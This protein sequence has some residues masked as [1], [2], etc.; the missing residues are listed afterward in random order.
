KSSAPLAHFEAQAPYSPDAVWHTEEY[1]RIYS[2]I[3]HKPIEKPLSTFSIDVDT[4]AYSNMRRFLNRAKLPPKDAIRIEE[5]LN[6]FEYAYQPPQTKA[7]TPFTVGTTLTNCPWNQN[8][9]LARIYLQ[10][11]KIDLEH[12]PPSN[13]VFLIDVSGS[14]SNPNKLPL[15]KKA[16]QLLVKNLRA[17]DRVAIIVYAGAAGVVLE[18]TSGD[19]DAKIIAA[20]DKLTAG[21]STAGGQGIELAY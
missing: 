15:L 1:S 20:L 19:Q 9:H 6:Y 13:L 2:N 21:G 17:Q 8:H 10:G 12:L 5:L 7:K 18:A 14:M 16:F 4:A 11:Q 3:F